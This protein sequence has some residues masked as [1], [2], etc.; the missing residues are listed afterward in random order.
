[1][2]VWS[3]RGGW[4]KWALDWVVCTW[5]MHSGELF[6]ISRNWLA[7]GGTISPESARPH[8]SKD[9]NKKTCLLQTVIHRFIIMVNCWTT[10]HSSSVTYKSKF[11]RG[12][13]LT[14]RQRS[15]E[16][17]HSWTITEH[18]WWPWRR[19]RSP[20]GNPGCVWIERKAGSAD[21]GCGLWNSSLFSTGWIAD[22]LTEVANPPKDRAWIMLLSSLN[23]WSQH[24]LLSVPVRQ[25]LFAV[26]W[27]SGTG[28]GGFPALQLMTWVSL[29]SSNLSAPWFLKM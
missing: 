7:L 22:S 29:L 5:V 8:M 16:S 3:G 2:V 26:M 11:P 10:L 23:Y 20:K 9:L 24:H 25:R 17:R 6:A 4:R 15:K 13:K 18:Q 28:L 21:V 27:L 14:R 12:S 19:K 1:M